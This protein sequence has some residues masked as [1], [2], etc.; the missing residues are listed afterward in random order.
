MDAAVLERPEVVETNLRQTPILTTLYDLI[1]A[2]NE[3]VEPEEDVLV[4]AAMVHLCN[5]G[6]ITC[7]RAYDGSAL[8]CG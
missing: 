2:L 6:R 3:Q 5:S 7:R 1:A 4:T 8:V